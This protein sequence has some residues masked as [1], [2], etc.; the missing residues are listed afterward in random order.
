MTIK[1]TKTELQQ[2]RE[3]FKASRPQFGKVFLGGLSK[4]TVYYYEIG[5]TPIPE[6]VMMLARTWKSLL[7]TMRG[8]NE[9][10]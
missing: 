2:I 6:G 8:E 10:V 4:T 1:K 7:D 3:E 9:K 5:K